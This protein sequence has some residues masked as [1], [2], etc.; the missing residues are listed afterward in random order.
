M[1]AST[2]GLP[3]ERDLSL[4]FDSTSRNASQPGNTAISRSETTPIEAVIIV[5][6]P[7]LYPTRLRTTG[8]GFCYN[9]AR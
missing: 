1:R 5:D 2:D 7:E 9:T 6:L 4:G 8:A 3:I